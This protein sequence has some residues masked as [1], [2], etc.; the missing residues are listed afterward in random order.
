MTLVL[1]VFTALVVALVMERRHR[2]E[3]ARL[4]TESRS[5]ATAAANAGEALAV[6]LALRWADERR[7]GR[8]R[9][10]VARAR[11][12]VE[13]LDLPGDT[14]GAILLA[15]ALPPALVDDRHLALP[16]ATRD[17]LRLRHG[18]EANPAGRWAGALLPAQVV[19]MALTLDGV[20]PGESERVRQQL[21]SASDLAPSLVQA[22]LARLDELLDLPPAD[23]AMG[24]LPGVGVVLCVRPNL[25]EGLSEDRRALVLRATEQRVRARLR[26]SDRVYLTDDD[27]IAWLPTAR[28]DDAI[29]LIS[30]LA[31][32]LQN[33]TV[34]DVR[35]GRIRC[36]MGSAVGPG[37]GL[38]MPDLV[39]VARDRCGPESNAAAS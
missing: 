5:G 18:G 17:I 31:P 1:C 28:S 19:E 32:A 26:P 29:T 20:L 14:R 22:T 21:L 24:G 13:Q 7:D 6:D 11:R 16:S 37:D 38:R 36:R 30:R 23:D 15:S 3:V 33:V 25:P 35:V 10:A 34:A 12:L 27:V 2:L 9:R 39:G 4:E 8:A